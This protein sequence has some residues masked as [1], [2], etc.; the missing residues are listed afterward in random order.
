MPP[1]PG[2]QLDVSRRIEAALGPLNKPGVVVA[3]ERAEGL[4]RELDAGQSYPDD[5]I[6]FRITN[7]RASGA[8]ARQSD[9]ETALADL[10][11]LVE[12]LSERIGLRP[13]D[14][15]DALPAAELCER[16]SISR[17]TLDRMRRRGLIGRRVE[18]GD[19]VV[20]I[21][22]MPETAAWF[23]SARQGELGRASRFTRI[24]DETQA[25][26]VRNAARYKKWAGLT[27]N[28]S[29]LLLA[30]K[31]GRSHEAVRQVLRKHDAK[32]PERALFD[33]APPVNAQR[34]AVIFR[35]WRMGVPIAD[36]A[37]KYRRSLA[38]IRRG[39]AIERAERLTLHRSDGSLQ[40]PV[41]P[42]FALP[43]AEDVFLAA[44]AVRIGLGGP[45]E[46]SLSALLATPINKPLPPVDDEK[47]RVVAYHFL[48]FRA[49]A[50]IGSLDRAHP[51]AQTIDKAET[52]LRW[53][54][55]LK[56]ELMRPYL[57][58]MIETIA[59]RLGRALSD[60]PLPAVRSVLRLGF[61]ALATAVDMA[62]PLRAGRLAGPIGLALDRAVSKWIKEQTPLA[63][64]NAPGRATPRPPA[65][66]TI[67]DWTR[68][69][70]PWQSWTEL[71]E[72]VVRAVSAD[73]AV[74]TSADL[75]H[76]RYGLGDERPLTV[77]EWA[78]TNGRQ[79]PIRASILDHHVYGEALTRARRAAAP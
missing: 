4:A 61:A 37:K 11:C 75:L 63:L 33:E 39:I 53:A 26:I 77:A 60:S 22:F 31:L 44:P 34:R 14:L 19:G 76:A 21:V 65:G 23:E 6:F 55:R 12:R 49:L 7:Q 18:G 41:L 59:G 66:T 43:E 38:S 62:D 50:L 69:V 73:G 10:A 16:W 42:T 30:K 28:A 47:A 79:S 35:A 36:M 3:I 24:P 74:G 45:G 32:F 20:R 72:R 46:R 48:R 51:Q 9:G 27:L 78:A 56:V 68:T 64:G 25:R 54:S 40:G 71:P 17:K 15:K 1:I 70:S 29:A 13:S 8:G 58:L 52:F 5:F 57:P 67:S 2:L